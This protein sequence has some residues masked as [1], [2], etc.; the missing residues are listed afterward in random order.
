MASFN[1][2]Y[3]LHNA[4]RDPNSVIYQDNLVIIIKDKY[5][6]SIHHFLVLPVGKVK[7]LKALTRSHIQL[8]EHMVMVAARLTDK[9]PGNSF[10]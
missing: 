9:F 3:G 4:M 1:W 7:D 6:K 2:K 8:I 10:W 5:P